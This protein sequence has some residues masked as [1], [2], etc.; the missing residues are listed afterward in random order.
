MAVKKKWGEISFS[1]EGIFKNSF[2]IRIKSLLLQNRKEQ[3]EA[4][5]NVFS[6]IEH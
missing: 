1:K 6:W 4:K 2:I 3:W 5:I